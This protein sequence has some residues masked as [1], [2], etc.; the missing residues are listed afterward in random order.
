M[1]MLKAAVKRGPAAA[2]RHG[3]AGESGARYTFREKRAAAGALAEA[4]FQN[5]PFTRSRE[6]T[7]VVGVHVEARA[8]LRRTRQRL[9]L[10]WKVG[11]LT[12]RCPQDR[13][14]IPPAST[15]TTRL[16][17]GGCN[18]PSWRMAGGWHATGPGRPFP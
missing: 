11:R 18:S 12:L 15:G 10:P 13:R 8:L 2:T 9:T 7:K 4:A 1:K 3:G 17:P 14:S 16:S 5:G 6:S